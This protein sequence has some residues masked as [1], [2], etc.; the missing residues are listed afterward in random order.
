MTAY[1]E[2]ASATT[3][4]GTIR[5]RHFAPCPNSPLSPT[6]ARR[7]PIVRQSRSRRRS[8]PT[9][10]RG[11]STARCRTGKSAARLLAAGPSGRHSRI[12]RQRSE[13]QRLVATRG[14]AA[15]CR[16][17]EARSE[18]EQQS[19]IAALTRTRRLHQTAT[20]FDQVSQSRR[21][22]RPA[23]VTERSWNCNNIVTQ[24]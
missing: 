11:R 6:R 13:Q 22:G 15:R 20:G 21:I 23:C 12:H 18:P 1:Q 16:A 9:G 4:T 7:S 19:N 24:R 8:R 2:Q 3:I 10:R 17:A 14:P 5:S